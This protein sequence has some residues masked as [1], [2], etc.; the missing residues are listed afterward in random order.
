MPNSST[1]QANQADARALTD[2]QD[3][4]DYQSG[5]GSRKRRRFQRPHV[6]DP[7]QLHPHSSS[8]LSTGPA[9]YKYTPLFLR[10][11]DLESLRYDHGVQFKKHLSLK[12]VVLYARWHLLL[13]EDALPS[14]IKHNS[15]KSLKAMKKFVRHTIKSCGESLDRFWSKAKEKISSS[16]T[17]VEGEALGCDS[18]E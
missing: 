16:Q 17:G 5:V 2:I 12:E 6:P 10:T 15:K 4:F 9:G 7:L 1:I 3:Y 11:P 8:P 18:Q 13:D 14:R